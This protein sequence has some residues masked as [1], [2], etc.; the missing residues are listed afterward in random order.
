MGSVIP[1]DD[2]DDDDDDD[3]AGRNG[4]VGGARAPCLLPP[5]VMATVCVH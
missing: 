1:D 4:T 3:E 5:V 2:D